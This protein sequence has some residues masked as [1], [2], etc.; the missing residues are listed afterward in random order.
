LR[1]SATYRRNLPE[2]W[3]EIDSS[4]HDVIDPVK[5]SGIS[6][7]WAPRGELVLRFVAA[8]SRADREDL[9]ASERDIA[10]A[11]LDAA[12]QAVGTGTAWG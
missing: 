7:V 4:L 9:L 8:K 1:R 11:D 2:N 3:Q 12:M 6:L 10:L 5:E